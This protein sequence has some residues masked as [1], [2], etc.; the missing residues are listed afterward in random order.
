[1]FWVGRGAASVPA[2]NDSLGQPLSH[3]LSGEREACRQTQTNR[4]KGGKGG[5]REVRLIRREIYK[6]VK[7]AV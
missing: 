6:T 5:I 1:M 7:L 3:M 2:L 4:L